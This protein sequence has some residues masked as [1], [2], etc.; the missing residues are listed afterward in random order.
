MTILKI[1]SKDNIKISESHSKF[2]ILIF[3]QS[4]TLVLKVSL[5]NSLEM[6]KFY[7]LY[8]ALMYLTNV[9]LDLPKMYQFIPFSSRMLSRG[10]CT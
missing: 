1:I 6:R 5:G 8:H 7:L 2:D 3:L 10:I 4:R 9:D